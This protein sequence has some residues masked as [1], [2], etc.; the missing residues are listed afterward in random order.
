[1]VDRG[2]YNDRGIETGIEWNGNKIKRWYILC[3][4]IIIIVL[5][6]IYST[7]SSSSSKPYQCSTSTSPPALIPRDTHFGNPPYARSSIHPSLTQGN[8]HPSNTQL[9]H[10]LPP[11]KRQAEIPSLP[12]QPSPQPPHPYRIDRVNPRR[13]TCH[14]PIPRVQVQ[15]RVQVQLSSAGECLAAA[16]SSPSRPRPQQGGYSSRG[17]SR[18]RSRDSKMPLHPREDTF[19]FIFLTRT[20]PPGRRGLRE[21]PNGEGELAMG[22]ERVRPCV[23]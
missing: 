2:G 14:L 16:I 4:T 17:G 19:L 6:A 20:V 21:M 18:A 5:L 13:E 8:T 22:G 10:N 11:H 1:M 12:P 9:P 23:Q 15:V 3:I 7:S